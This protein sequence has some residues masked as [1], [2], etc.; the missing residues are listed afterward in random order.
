MRFKQLLREIWYKKC[1]VGRAIPFFS[2]C[3]CDSQR[4]QAHYRHQNANY[5]STTSNPDPSFGG[6]SCY[7]CY[8][9]PWP[10]Q[11]EPL[12]ASVR[13]LKGSR[14]LDTLQYENR[15]RW[16]RRH[17]GMD[18]PRLLDFN[19]RAKA[20]DIS[21]S[22][23]YSLKDCRIHICES[24]P[25]V[26]FLG[27]RL[28]LHSLG[29]RCSASQLKL[30]LILIGKLSC[31][32]STKKAILL[33]PWAISSRKW[34]SVII[35]REGLGHKTGAG[36]HFSDQERQAE[37]TGTWWSQRTASR[38]EVAVKLKGYSFWMHAIRS[39]LFLRR[40]GRKRI[41]QITYGWPLRGTRM[42]RIVWMIRLHRI[43]T[44]VHSVSY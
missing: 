23:S 13:P 3:D 20:L 16:Y 21:S 38:A 25:P 31:R 18:V 33:P 35:N 2:K 7:Q 43:I 14:A 39:S 41:T 36:E 30:F 10:S 15:S 42:W 17:I 40:I 9:S 4:R 26:H 5:C 34:N 11:R 12:Y 6:Q 37:L 22:E 44:T 8:C 32:S 24:S 27:R 28:R 1:K 29:V 19:S